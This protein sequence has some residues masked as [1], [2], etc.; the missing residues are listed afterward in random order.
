MSRVS[1]QTKGIDPTTFANAVA[2]AVEQILAARSTQPIQAS[3][4][5]AISPALA[6]PDVIDYSTGHGAKIFSKATE[7]LPTQ[8]N[9]KNPNIRV[10]LSKI[11]VQ[12]E[13]FG[14]HDLLNINISDDDQVPTLKSLTHEHGQ[15]SL[16]QVN[17]ESTRYINSNTRKRQNNY[18]LFVCINQSIDNNTKRVLA[19][20][21]SKYHINGH[22]CG[23]TYLKLLLQ[24]AEVD[25]RATA[26]Y[27]QRNLTQLHNYMQTEAQGDITKFNQY[28]ND[29]MTTLSS[30]GG[31]SSDIIINLFTGYMACSDK[32]FVEYI[33]KCQD[34]YED[35]AH[36]TY[37]ELMS[38]AEKKY[39][40]RVMTKEWNT[41][42][43]EQEE[44][45]AL[46]AQLAAI[47]DKHVKRENN[48][49]QKLSQKKESSQHSK[50][51]YHKNNKNKSSKQKNWKSIKPAPDEPTSKNIEGVTWH[52]CNNHQYWCKHET[53]DCLMKKQKTPLKKKSLEASMA[54]ATIGVNDIY[55]EDSQS[56]E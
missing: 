17:R 9:V 39:Q 24:K 15:C 42:T 40:A 10:L 21:E 2:A 31:T 45:V 1:R 36:F 53:K 7:P 54:M 12:A 28:V 8:F 4:L 26:L 30:R 47:S 18:Q 51:S 52:Y 11:Q 37:Q 48:N 56:D 19:T 29:L 32:K 13:S 6:Q 38:K 43:S 16:E 35:G 20:E 49:N 3:S 50:K 25:T 23:V 46:K 33:E 34:D 22:P 55:D 44:I 14:W 27:I 41:L 5:F